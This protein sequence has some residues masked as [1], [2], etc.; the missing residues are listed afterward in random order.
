[1]S[2]I[3]AK[4]STHL[5]TVVTRYERLRAAMLGEVLPPEA[6]SGLIVVLQQ[7]LWRWTCTVTSGSG[8]RTPPPASVLGPSAEPVEQRLVIHALA[9]MAMTLNDRRIA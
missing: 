9:A 8:R 7:G 1:M 2:A 3:A 6:R 4:P 5:A